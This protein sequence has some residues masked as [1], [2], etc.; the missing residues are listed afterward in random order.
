MISIRNK[1]FGWLLIL[2]LSIYAALGAIMVFMEAREAY[3]SPSHFEDEVPEIAAFGLVMLVTFPVAVF[4]AWLIAGRLL[5]PLQDMLATA[6]SIR[7]GN[8]EKRIMPP[9]EDNELGRLAAT[10][11]DAFDRYALAVQRLESFSA[12]ASHQLRTPIAVIRT[13][14]EVAL[15]RERTP[16]DYQETIADM[17]E[18]TGR[19]NQTVEQLLLLARMD[20]SLRD[21]FKPVQLARVLAAWTSEVSELFES[22]EI[23]FQADSSCQSCVVSGNEVLL[24]QCFDNLVNNA[25]DA[26]GERGLILVTILERDDQLHW[27]VEDNGPGIPASE[28]PAI[29]DRFYRGTSR[30]AKGSGLGL[31]I[32]KEIINLHGG[33]VHAGQSS[34]LGGAAIHLTLPAGR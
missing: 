20:H 4:M 30:T 21:D 12:D 27:T 25:V 28:R 17:L 16:A 18:Q 15:Q 24:R 31:A 13:S 22:C 11:N 32:V 9:A 2:M 26:V 7:G 19:L 8:L 6:E 34:S 1:Y 23:N 29:F 14:A 10:I 33:H 5:K 3:V